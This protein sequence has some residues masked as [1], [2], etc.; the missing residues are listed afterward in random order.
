M[1]SLSGI[2]SSAVW[3]SPSGVHKEGQRGP[4]PALRVVGV[5]MDREVEQAEKVLAAVEEDKV[6]PLLVEP[7]ARVEDRWKVEGVDPSDV[8]DAGREHGRAPSGHFSR[9]WFSSISRVLA[10][11]FC[12][13]T[14]WSELN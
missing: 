1:R 4:V 14:S 8:L 11:S 7:D 3:T 2:S 13:R 5:P 9:V 10:E 6:V 12:S